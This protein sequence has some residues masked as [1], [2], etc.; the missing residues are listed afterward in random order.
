[1]GGGT[2]APSDAM[3]LGLAGGNIAEFVAG[4]AL[5]QA[6][7]TT[8]IP[9]GSYNYYEGYY[10][11]DAWQVSPKLTVDCGN[12]LSTYFGAGTI[13]PNVVP[14]VPKK[15]GGSKHKC[16]SGSI[17]ASSRSGTQATPAKMG[18]PV[19][20]GPVERRNEERNEKQEGREKDEEVIACN[21]NCGVAVDKPSSECYR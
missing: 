16:P 13:R 3:G 17:S 21:R 15:V 20:S 18:L 5:G 4:M 19:K 9:D 12:N 11:T 10:V 2:V 6:S 1:M 14:G 8:T 7:L